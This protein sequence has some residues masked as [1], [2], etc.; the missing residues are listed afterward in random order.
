MKSIRSQ[1]PIF[2]HTKA[3]GLPLVFLDN[4]STTQKPNCV[5]NTIT[6]F[7][8]GYYA[9]VG[10]GLY[11]QANQTT[12]AYA[13]AREKVR[14]FIGAKSTKA[15]V[16]TSGTTDAI[17][18]VVDNYLTPRLGEGDIIMVTD[19]EHHSNYVPWQQACK[20]AN[21][22]FDIIPL[23]DDLSIDFEAF[24]NTL[25]DKVKM[26]AVSAISNVL[27][28]KHD[29]SRL[30]EIAHKHNIKVLVDAAQLPLAETINVQQLN[31][32]FLVFSGH[33]VFGPTGIGVLYGK[34]E[35]LTQMEPLVFGGGMVRLVEKEE[36]SFLS[37]PS[38]H[39]AGTPNIA[40]ALGLAAAIDFVQ[41]IGVKN[42]AEHS[43]GLR[44]YAVNRLSDIEGIEIYGRDIAGSSI[45]AFN[46]NEVHPHDVATFLAEKGI[47]VRAGH[48][49]AQPLMKRLKTN[50]VVRA[51]F[52]IYNTEDEVD[53]LKTTLVE[54][55]DF[56]S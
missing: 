14:D 22:S 5:I 49:C 26:I 17:N 6:Q 1:F 15:I 25:S 47:A 30:I 20:Q 51:S 36:S 34:E 46:I 8:S 3:Q 19:L 23:H 11:Q 44:N 55:K 24:E 32:D 54:I 39:E 13:K 33:K 16:F 48:H 4:A 56:F 2:E 41:S 21:A 40:G 29:L 10:R 7:Y 12:T 38:K 27:G 37:L 45:L 50:S 42:I 18:K 43:V 28:V 31:C 35:L 9:N 53:L 52:S